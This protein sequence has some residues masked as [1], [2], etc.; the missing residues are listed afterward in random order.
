MMDMT[1]SPIPIPKSSHRCPTT[2]IMRTSMVTAMI[3]RMVTRSTAS[4]HQVLMKAMT[5]PV[6]SSVK[7]QN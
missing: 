5:I 6:D 4:M 7:K 1:I 3:I 2:Q